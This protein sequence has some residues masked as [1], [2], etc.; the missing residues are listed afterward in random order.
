MLKGIFRIGGVTFLLTAAVLIFG[1]DKAQAGNVSCNQR[2]VTISAGNYC[3]V[4]TRTEYTFAYEGST[5]AS[6]KVT[7]AGG[8]VYKT[9]KGSGPNIWACLS[10][11][12]KP[13]EPLRFTVTSGT[14]RVYG[15]S[16]IVSCN[17]SAGPAGELQ[18]R[19]SPVS[20]VA[21]VYH[22]NADG[23][24]YNFTTPRNLHCG[25]GCPMSGYT[26]A[27]ASFS[28][29]GVNYTFVSW[30]G[31]DSASGTRCNT[32]IPVGVT[33]TV[34]ANYRSGTLSCTPLS[35]T[36]IRW[37][38]TYSHA[39]TP[40]LARTNTGIH[41]FPSGTNTDGTYYDETGL[42]PGTPYNMTFKNTGPTG[43]VL[44]GPVT[45]GTLGEPRSPFLTTNLGDVHAGG[46]I[47]Y[48]IVC[49]VPS[50][51]GT[52][53]GQGSAKGDYVVS[54]GGNVG[55]FRS[56]NSASNPLTFGNE[57]GTLGFYQGVCRPNLAAA[58]VD[59]ANRF[60]ASTSMTGL[61]GTSPT[62][63]L[64]RPG[65]GN[66]SLGATTIS[67]QRTLFVEGDLTIT[68]NV[69]Y[70][71]ALVSRAQLPSFGVI[72][73]GNIYINGN[74]TQLDG[75]YWARNRIDTC[76]QTTTITATACRTRLLVRGLM[77]ANN[78]VFDRAATGTGAQ[79]SET[80]GGVQF[81]LLYLAT[82]PAFT[83]FISPTATGT[84]DEG[85][86]PPLF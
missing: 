85:E 30:T 58:A 14:L 83:D 47:G 29:G 1:A 86:R 50:G 80:I 33:Q 64:I 26:T 51:G 20:G 2:V 7:R 44:A 59:Y 77:M 16:P 13:G 25:T 69:V 35:K 79:S 75:F 72:A 76:G 55:N 61:A 60:G 18:V 74:V 46:G 66:R 82:P 8:E 11:A 49:G 67:R 52:I 56:G 71:G 41:S 24:N 22:H 31:C 63:R 15:H 5:S 4:G 10:T 21:M 17:T 45:C 53:A 81:G 34:T 12:P 32:S 48:N 27:P 68:G 54:A 39:T 73:T 70:S 28:Q 37:S 19:S 23:L 65:V 38:V 43:T 78:F 6:W 42:S 57:G 9:G 36:S 3:D 40:T 84:S 62:S